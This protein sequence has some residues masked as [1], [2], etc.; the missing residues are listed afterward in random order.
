MADPTPSLDGA[1][2]GLRVQGRKS[3]GEPH[4]ACDLAPTPAR[5]NN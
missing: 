5:G 3:I 2:L 1:D 4:E